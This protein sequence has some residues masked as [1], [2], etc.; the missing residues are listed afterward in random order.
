MVGLGDGDFQGMTASLARMDGLM[1]MLERGDFDL[2]AVGR[3]LIANPAWPA[4]V[5]QG[6]VDEL[7]DFD[8]KTMGELV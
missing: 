2:V 3:A 8:R 4:L 5:R 7:A 6:R 1:R